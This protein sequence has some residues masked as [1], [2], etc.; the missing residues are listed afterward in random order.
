MKTSQAFRLTKA[1]VWDG[2]GSR[3]KNRK[4][5][6]CHAAS[7]ALDNPWQV[8]GIINNL[9]DGYGTLE[10]WLYY[11]GFLPYGT[12]DHKRVQ[13]TRHAWLDHLIEHYESLGD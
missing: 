6:I 9:L 7:C 4:A 13:A 5:Y 8:E 10:G 11:R 1:K 12:N 3:P 2:T